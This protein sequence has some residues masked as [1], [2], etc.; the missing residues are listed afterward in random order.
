MEGEAEKAGLKTE[1]DVVAFVKSIRKERREK[2]H[3]GN[4]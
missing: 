3:E 2:E 1:E 4:N